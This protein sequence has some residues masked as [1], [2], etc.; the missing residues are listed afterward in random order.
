MLQTPLIN[1]RKEMSSLSHKEISELCIRLIRYKKEN[2]E[3]ADY[4]LFE[5]H[6]EHSYLLSAKSEI[7]SLFGNIQTLQPYL[8]KKS[9]RKII[10]LAERY[11]KYAANPIIF[12]ELYLEIMQQM[13]EHFPQWNQLE[14]LVKIAQSLEKKSMRLLPKLHEDLQFDYNARL[15]I[16]QTH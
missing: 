12:L 2:K 13:R 14:P 1:I 9:I 8:V 3:L 16:F 6:Q 11:S 10:R 15:E 7:Q 5:K 4:F